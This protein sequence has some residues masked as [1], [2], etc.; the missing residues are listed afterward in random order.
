MTIDIL[1]HLQQAGSVLERNWSVTEALLQTLPSSLADALVAAAVPHWFNPPVLGALLEADGSAAEQLYNELQSLPVSESFGALGHTLHDL[2]RASVL[3]HL[4][5]E[6]HEVFTDYSRRAQRLFSGSQDLTQRSSFP[7]SGGPVFSY[8]HPASGDPWNLATSRN[9]DCVEIW[10]S[11]D[12]YNHNFEAT[13][14]FW[15]D[16]L[17]R[18]GKRITAVGGSDMH[19]LHGASASS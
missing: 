2:T 6:D 15:D 4:V 1:E 5:K 11:V 14:K 8:N 13:F 19:N 18:F 17:L 3:F 10:N 9:G 16:L 12:D 7:I